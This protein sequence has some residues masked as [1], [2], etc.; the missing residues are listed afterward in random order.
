MMMVNFSFWEKE[1]FFK[2][3]DVLIIGSG[4]VGLNVVIVIKE[5]KFRYKVIVFERGVLFIGVS[6]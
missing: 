1:V 2:V 5:R 4:I 6:I 3:V